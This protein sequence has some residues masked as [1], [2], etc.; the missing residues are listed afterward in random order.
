ME[1]ETRHRC[2]V[3]GLVAGLPRNDD[4]GEPAQRGS[5]IEPDLVIRV[6][7]VDESY[8]EGRLL[9]QHTELLRILGVDEPVHL[10]VE[11]DDLRRSAVENWSCS[12]LVIEVTMV[13]GT[14]N[15]CL[16]TTIINGKT[17]DLAPQLL[18]LKRPDG[19]EG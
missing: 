7:S 2:S 19:F 9:V 8:S 4:V 11:E 5:L 16:S 13:S 15:R 17:S 18:V 6:G 12:S 1:I 3:D 10:L 14:L